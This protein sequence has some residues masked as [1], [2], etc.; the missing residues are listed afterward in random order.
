MRTDELDQAIELAEGIRAL[1][2]MLDDVGTKGMLSVDMMLSINR[3]CIGNMLQIIELIKK[4]RKG[5]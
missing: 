3:L 2:I 5:D 1:M 4:E